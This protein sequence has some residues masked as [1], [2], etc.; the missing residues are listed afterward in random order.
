[1]A[2][3]WI[4]LFI[5]S[6]LKQ[7]SGRC[8]NP[9]AHKEAIGALENCKESNGF[10]SILL[11]FTAFSIVC[12]KIQRAFALP[13]LEVTKSARKVQIARKVAETA[14]LARQNAWRKKN[15]RMTKCCHNLP[16]CGMFMGFWSERPWCANAR[17]SAIS[18]SA[19]RKSSG[20]QQ[21]NWRNFG[22]YWQREKGGQLLR[23]QSAEQM[24]GSPRRGCNLVE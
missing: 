3:Q 22:L 17:I 7:K 19:V 21:M 2:N 4:H 13:I 10:P 11:H 12:S 20:W 8:A 5:Q 15:M 16:A 14:W 23:G 1:M 24:M 6:F 18:L 9:I